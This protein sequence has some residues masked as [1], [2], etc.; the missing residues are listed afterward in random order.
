MNKLIT[1]KRI[2]VFSLYLLLAVIVFCFFDIYFFGYQTNLSKFTTKIIPYPA[3]I[4]NNELVTIK[5]YEDFLK[6]YELYLIESNIIRDGEFNHQVALKNM[7][8]NIILEQVVSSLNIDIDQQELD[9]Y[10]SGFQRNNNITR[11]DHG[12]LKIYFLKPLFYRNKILEKITEDQFNLENKKKIEIIYGELNDSPEIFSTY[13]NLYQD[14]D[15]GIG[16]DLMGWLSYES[17]PE[18][19]KSRVAKIKVGDF[20]SV[21]KSVS[22]YHIYKLNGKI[23]NEDD[24]YYYQFDQIFLPIKN[25]NNYLDSFLEESKIF[26]FFKSKAD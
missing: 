10:V 8:Q 14:T 7:V 3:L 18:S 19:L 9:N 26:H 17:L 23:N 24:N 25:F 1:K 21:I 11:I 16:G 13:A 12:R 2:L 20:T 6:D 5:K 15:L 22:G 4:V